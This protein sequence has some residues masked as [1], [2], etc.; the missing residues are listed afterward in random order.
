MRIRWS[1][2][3]RRQLDEAGAYIARDKPEAADRLIQRIRLAVENLADFPLLGRPGRVLGTRELIVPE[4]PYI[5]A[6]RVREQ[7]V[8]VLTVHHA[9]RRWPESFD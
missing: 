1:R 8:E 7:T 4:T 6:Y 5:V 3:A 2:H 9:A